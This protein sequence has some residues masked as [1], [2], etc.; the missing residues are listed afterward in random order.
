MYTF[1][2]WPTWTIPNMHQVIS[3]VAPVKSRRMLNMASGALHKCHIDSLHRQV[4]IH[5][6][7][8]SLEKYQPFPRPA[9]AFV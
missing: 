1:M 9:Y 2:A 4:C 6:E 3:V 7:Y 8:M 5:G